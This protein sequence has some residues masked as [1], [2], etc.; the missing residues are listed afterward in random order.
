MIE[1]PD[2][3]PLGSV[4]RIKGSS[5][6]LLVIGRALAVEADE[7]VREYYDYSLALYPEGLIG[8][9]VI[10]TNHDCIEEVLFEGFSDAEDR[11]LTELLGDTV[12]KLNLRKGT[13]QPVGEW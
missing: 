4:V 2:F 6:K 11:E 9:A 5:K 12:P 13:P 10:Y 1:A 3:L 7:G 8:D